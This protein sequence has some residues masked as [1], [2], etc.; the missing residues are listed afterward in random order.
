MTKAP[1]QNEYMKDG[2]IELNAFNTIQN[3]TNRIG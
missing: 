2:M 3:S 1:N